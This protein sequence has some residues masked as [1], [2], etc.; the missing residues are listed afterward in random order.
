MPT[1]H[2]SHL[3]GILFFPYSHSSQS[4]KCITRSRGETL[5][6]DRN[7]SP[8]NPNPEHPDWLSFEVNPLGVGVWTVGSSKEQ[9]APMEGL[10]IRCPSIEPFSRTIR[11]SANDLRQTLYEC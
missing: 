9:L 7:P 5:L 4:Q 10:H 11:H 2:R 1:P 3:L 6:S 8:A